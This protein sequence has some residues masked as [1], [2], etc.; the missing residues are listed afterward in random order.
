MIFSPIDNYVQG[1][2][3]TILF[4]QAVSDVTVIVGF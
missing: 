2:F 4:L 3:E 1:D